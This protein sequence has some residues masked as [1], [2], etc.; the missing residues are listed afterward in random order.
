MTL[1]IHLTVYLNCKT[2]CEKQLSTDLIDPLSNIIIVEIKG[3][4]AQ[5]TETSLYNSNRN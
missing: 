5:T 3:G 4:L 2:K 1:N